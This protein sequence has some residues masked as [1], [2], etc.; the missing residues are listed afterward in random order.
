MTAAVAAVVVA[1]LVGSMKGCCW[2]GV[3]AIGVSSVVVV[4]VV[5]TICVPTKQFCSTDKVN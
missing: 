1:G 2:P 3:P 5:V 4:F